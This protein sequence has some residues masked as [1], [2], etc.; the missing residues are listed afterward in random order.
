MEPA[1]RT[2]TGLTEEEAARRL[3]EHG[4]N[5]IPQPKPP[6]LIVR[7]ARQL[8]D[9]MSVLLLVAGLVTLLVLGE[10]P[11]GAAILAILLVN[12]VIGVAQETKADK[13]VRALHTLT[14]PM[15]TVVRGDVVRRIPAAQVVPGDIVTV[16]AGDRVPADAR[17][18]E[19]SAL[20]VD[21]A[22]LTGE[23]LS[24][25]KRA[26]GAGGAGGPHVPLGDRTGEI[27][28]GT[29]VVRGSGTAEVLR[30]G[31][32]TEVG[33]IATALGGG[34]KGPLE[35][36]LGQVSRR[37]GL[38][39]VAAGTLM[40]LIGLTRVSRGEAA[41]IDII[42]AGVALAIAAV[43]ESM[44]AA[45]TTALA[46]GAQRMAKLGV[47][48]RRLPAMEALG[49]TTVIATDKTGTLTTGHL[50]VADHLA[51]PGADLWRAAL[52]CNDARDGVGDAVDVALA[53]AAARHGVRLSPAETRLDAR[54][55][56]AETRSMA[57]V[58]ALDGGPPLL[59]VK[60]APEAVLARCAPGE[61]TDRLAQAV[62]ELARRGL[63]VL[64]LAEG[65]TG[66]LDATGLRP[67][68]LVALQDEIRASAR[69]AVADCRGAGIRVVMVT[70]DHAETARAVAQEV[71]I[72]PEPLV[73]GAAIEGDGGRARLPEAAVVA[74][75]DPETK[76]DLVRALKERGEVVAMTGDGVNDAP[77]LRHADVGVA[78]AGEEGT[79]VA[80]EA[81]AVVVTNGELGTIVT[82]VREG[83]RLH[84][85]VASM[86]GYLLTG[87]LAEILIVLTGLLVW[88]DL[89]VPLLPVHLLWINLVLDGIPAIALG[90]DRPA[91]D[92]L[93]LRPR[94]DGLLSWRV[95]RRILLR[96]VVVA[97]LVFAVVETA[98]RL[99]WSDE[100]VRTQAV[101][102]L[103]FARL[104]L[105]YVVRARR[106]TFERGWWH[107]R[108]VA[109]AVSATLILQVLVTAVPVL[110]APLALVPLPPLGWA[111]AVAAAVLTVLLCDA[112]RTR[113][114][115]RGAA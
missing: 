59:T 96:S 67:V 75:V 115:S 109:A 34:G 13:A 63:R 68:G 55:F 37:I 69:Q 29:L 66:D 76:L 16:A 107:G 19:T 52:R 36:E 89:V 91:G 31:S 80:R 105:A 21:E 77:A 9:P 2:L 15:A 60:G 12:V 73:T 85:N 48:V 71:G 42:L 104:T 38:L 22:L 14:A 95:L 1:V 7:A 103:V 106:R 51:V 108:A 62:P 11:E 41:L 97:V 27:F 61:Q 50:T 92:P 44:A 110:G 58:T 28:S 88:P 86:I 78:M 87:N 70:G 82:G 102:A 111:M 54:P 35:I 18:I 64:A 74:R 26:G 101:L 72:D 94:G 93:A 24:A 65:R 99:G 43:P 4:P 90:V 10:V 114:A 6:N 30:T 46:M 83:R 53:E 112:L 32:G 5:E 100:Q 49:A 81:A 56:D 45:V 23:S 20:A 17:L 3:A 98:R 57:V 40:V 8:A 25:D 113:E 79:D 33:R 47:I 84:H 39:A